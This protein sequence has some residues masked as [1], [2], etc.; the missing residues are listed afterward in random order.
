[1]WGVAC[2]SIIVGGVVWLVFGW[3]G[4]D[5]EGK[6]KRKKGKKKG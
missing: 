3:Y 1:M 5:D 4:D 6:E 2:L